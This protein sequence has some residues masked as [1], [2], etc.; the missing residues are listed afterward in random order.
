MSFMIVLHL[1]FAS[2]LRIHPLHRRPFS[3]RLTGV[4]RVA[5][6]SM[7]RALDATVFVGGQIVPGACRFGLLREEPC[8]SG[9]C[10]GDAGY[11][12]LA[13]S[14]NVVERWNT[15]KWNMVSGRNHYRIHSCSIFHYRVLEVPLERRL[16]SSTNMLYIPLL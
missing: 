1:P 12:A 16:F 9:T 10:P 8:K 11:A 15:W 3:T 14:S 6:P 5:Q 7:P 13:T 2:A 4:H